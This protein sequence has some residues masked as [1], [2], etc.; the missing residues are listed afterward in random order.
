MCKST[1]RIMSTFLK[2]NICRSGSSRF[3]H[4]RIIKQR[5]PPV[6]L[7]INTIHQEMLFVFPS[8][9]IIDHYKSALPL[10]LD[11]NMVY[12][13]LVSKPKIVLGRD[14][15]IL[16]SGHQIIKSRSCFRIRI[17][18]V[19]HD[20]VS[21]TTIL[22]ISIQNKNIFVPIDIPQFIALYKLSPFFVLC[23]FV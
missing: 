13:H 11:Y 3:S 16:K 10:E 20:L 15:H 22:Q 4:S 2:S 12:N 17:P 8:R 14:S 5:Q 21:K 9:E 7:L 23:A 18:T 19:S 1:P 6:S